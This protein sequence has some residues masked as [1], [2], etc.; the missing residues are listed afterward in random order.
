MNA[1]MNKIKI[2]QNLSGADD[3]TKRLYLEPIYTTE[4]IANQMETESRMFKDVDRAF[5]NIIEMIDTNPNVIHITETNGVLDML[6][7]S[8]KTVKGIY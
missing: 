8:D 2:H 1:A 5:K 6:T 4:E 7:K 3:S